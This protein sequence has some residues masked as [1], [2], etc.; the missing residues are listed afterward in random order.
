M[1]MDLVARG[2]VDAA[3]V[4]HGVESRTHIS[5]SGN[6][7]KKNHRCSRSAASR[8]RVPGCGTSS[9]PGREVAAIPPD[10]EVVHQAPVEGDRCAA[11]QH[12]PV[13]S[14]RYSTAHA[15]PASASVRLAQ[16]LEDLLRSGTEGGQRAP[17]ENLVCLKP[18][19][20][21][22]LGARWLSSADMRCFRRFWWRCHKHHKCKARGKI[23]A[24]AAQTPGSASV[25]SSCGGIPTASSAKSGD[26]WS[27]AATAELLGV[28][29]G[30]AGATQ[31]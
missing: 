16:F 23:D 31:G 9:S 28:G 21:L 4:H 8:G 2:R 20:Y 12:C 5:S 19:Q 10:T 30:R 29:G 11:A 26:G 14:A 25:R 22:T 15:G 17:V 3:L 18:A 6:H 27:S 13:V 1:R 7:K 24:T